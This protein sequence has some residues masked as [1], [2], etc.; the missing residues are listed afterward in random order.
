MTTKKQ[1]QTQKETKRI[2]R[3]ES[4][5]FHDL[6]KLD[7]EITF[8]NI[9]IYKK[10]PIW[11]EIS[12]KHFYHTYNSDGRRQTRCAPT[13]GHFHDVEVKEVNG[14]FVANVGPA[15][16]MITRI[17]RGKSVREE[18]LLDD[19]QQHTHEAVYMQSEE[20]TKRKFSEEAAKVISQIS[21]S[22]ASRLENPCL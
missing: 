21:S 5:V 16:K 6:F 14:E 17:R 12:H 13:A 3:G 10:D 11:E 7:T 1:T 20:L 4:V 9:S 18:V 15:K 19:K 2:M 22:E 8:K